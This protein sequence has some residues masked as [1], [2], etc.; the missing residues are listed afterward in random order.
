MNVYDFQGTS[1]VHCKCGKQYVLTR[2][3]YT[4]HVHIINDA[5]KTRRQCNVVHIYPALVLFEQVNCTDWIYLYIYC[6]L[7]K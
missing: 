5:T 1:T 2:G 3:G 6:H 4:I 7:P